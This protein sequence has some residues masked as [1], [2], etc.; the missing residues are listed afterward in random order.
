MLFNCYHVGIQQYYVKTK[1]KQ[2]G[3]KCKQL[4]NGYVFPCSLW[5]MIISS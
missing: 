4:V 1:N 3:T 2:I 5:Y